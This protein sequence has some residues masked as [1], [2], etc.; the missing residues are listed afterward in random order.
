MNNFIDNLVDKFNRGD[1]LAIIDNSQ[2]NL[3]N[4]KN[5]F[6]YLKILALSYLNLGRYLEAIENLKEC[7]NIKNDD[8]DIKFNL[9]I[10]YLGI[11]DFDNTISIFKDLLK[12]NQNSYIVYNNLGIAYSQNSKPKEAIK[13]FLKSINLNKNFTD[14]IYNVGLTY[15]IISDLVNAEIAFKKV[16]EL[17]KTYK[18]IELYLSITLRKLKKI[19]ECLDILKKYYEKNKNKIFVIYELGLAYQGLGEYKKSIKYFNKCLKIKPDFIKALNGIGLC[20]LKLKK[21]D[22]A[23]INFNKAINLKQDF[24]DPYINIGLLNRTI[25]NFDKAH[26]YYSKAI[27]I[28]PNSPDANLGIAMCLLTQGKFSEGWKYYK[29]R[30]EGKNLS[31][32]HNEIINIPKAKDIEDLKNKKLLIFCEQGLGDIILFSRYLKILLSYNSKIFFKAPKPLIN[33]LKTLDNKII[34]DKD[35]PKDKKFDYYCSLIDIPI[36]LNSTLESI[37]SFKRY[38]YPKNEYLNKWKNDINTDFYN[39]AICWRGSDILEGRWIPIELFNKL[40]LI[41]NIRLISIQKADEKYASDKNILDTSNI[42]HFEN[43]L[44]IKESFADTAAIIELCDLVITVDTSIAHLSGAL[45]SKVFLLLE[46]YPAW[47]WLL[48]SKNTKWYPNTTIYRQNQSGN[49]KNIF[50]NLY[51]DLKKITKT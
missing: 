51:K 47:F 32:I 34:V 5:N 41:K 15:F 6:I 4:Y 17:D 40:S 28:D 49:W 46:K 16:Y 13:Y 20:C 2:N 38:L 45:G 42:I 12:T 31:K 21:F 44:D 33:I 30:F 27:S 23:L 10:A 8:F 1:F 25:G 9:G 37:P 43:K 14:P 7:L 39:V 26:N 11:K 24:V 18:D 29:W 19:D 35:L 22:L 50:D 48:D 3:I 36:I